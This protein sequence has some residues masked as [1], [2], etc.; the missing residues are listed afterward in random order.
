MSI[1]QLLQPNSYNLNASSLSIKD[2]I[3]D[4]QGTKYTLILPNDNNA[5]PNSVLLI[6]SI[7]DD[8]VYLKWSFPINPPQSPFDIIECNRL[9]ANVDITSKSLTSD[10]LSGNSSNF[11]YN[12][13]EI[14]DYNLPS[15]L[16]NQNSILKSDGIGNL[17]WIAEPIPLRHYFVNFSSTNLTASSPSI[18]LQTVFSSL[19]PSM[20]Y[21]VFFNF[22]L[23][24]NNPTGTFNL[25]YSLSFSNIETQYGLSQSNISLPLVIGGSTV[26]DQSDYYKTNN[27]QIRATNVEL[28]SLV[29]LNFSTDIAG[30]GDLTINQITVVLQPINYNQI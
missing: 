8:K 14:I 19:V 15:T 26:P 2:T 13:N 21:N 16:P 27:F 10:N 25:S 28:D 4:S 24:K 22:N 29:S 23:R 3:L 30:Q 5:G 11:I 17:E 20:Y 7:I 9:I 12:G 1:S 18:T 6:D